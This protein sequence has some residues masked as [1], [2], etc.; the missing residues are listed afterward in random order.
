MATISSKTIS[1]RVDLATHANVVAA[2]RPGENVNDFLAS[3][4]AGELLRRRAGA[5]KEPSLSDIGQL[6]QAS[7]TK[8][9]LNQ[10][11]LTLIDSKLNRLMK[12]LDVQS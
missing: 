4:V 3:A 12:E 8:A 2:L 7:V 6:A 11:M 10:S 1:A 5:T 9:A